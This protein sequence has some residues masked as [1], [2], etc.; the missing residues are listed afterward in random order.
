MFINLFSSLTFNL[1]VMCYYNVKSYTT[2]K[3]KMQMLE[4]FKH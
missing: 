4:I 2:L 3:N 1:I